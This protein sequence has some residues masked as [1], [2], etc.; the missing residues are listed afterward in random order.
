[1]LYSNILNHRN[2][3]EETFTNAATKHVTDERASCTSDPLTQQ[4]VLNTR[5]QASENVT[6]GWV[7]GHL[8]VFAHPC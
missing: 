7:L 6:T 2:K 4:M 1:M 3:K 5:G 8:T